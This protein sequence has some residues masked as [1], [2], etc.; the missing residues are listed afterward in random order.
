MALMSLTYIVYIKITK[1]RIIKAIYLRKFMVLTIASW[2]NILI[3]SG[4]TDTSF[5]HVI[6]VSVLVLSVYKRLIKTN[7]I[8][9]QWTLR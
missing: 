4:W 9:Q 2:I 5:L 7:K 1:Q 6:V 8:K 3:K